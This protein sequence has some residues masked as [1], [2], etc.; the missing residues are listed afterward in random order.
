MVVVYDDSNLPA[1]IRI[2]WKA[3]KAA[4]TLAYFDVM[5][6][7]KIKSFTILTQ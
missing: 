3:N 1:N 7:M 4:N 5:K 6:M 2:V